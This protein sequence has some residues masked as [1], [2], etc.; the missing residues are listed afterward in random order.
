[1]KFI[2]ELSSILRYAVGCEEGVLIRELNGL[3]SE[4][5]TLLLWVLVLFKRPAIESLECVLL[6]HCCRGVRLAQVLLL[7]LVRSGLNVSRGGLLL[8]FGHIHQL[9]AAYF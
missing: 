4:I 5:E 1:M 3:I 9:Q 6:G 7:L 2:L 8:G